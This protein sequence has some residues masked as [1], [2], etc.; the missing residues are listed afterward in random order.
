MEPKIP[1]KNLNC[2][3]ALWELCQSAYQQQ[4]TL[5]LSD[6]S[7]AAQ[8]AQDEQDGTHCDEEVSHVQHL[9]QLTWSTLCTLQ[10]TQDR[11]TVH[12]HPDPHTQNSCSCQ[13]HNKNTNRFDLSMCIDPHINTLNV[14][15]PIKCHC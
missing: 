12:L 11:P 13:L 9:P 8:E 15:G 7:T 10:K 1:I 3:S 4:H 5:A 6:G 2:K 14:F